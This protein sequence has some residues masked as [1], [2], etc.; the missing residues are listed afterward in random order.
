VDE[1]G[2]V[3]EIWRPSA[4]ARW[5]GWAGWSGELSGIIE[6]G[7][8]GGDEHDR[9]ATL[10]F[11][12][13]HAAA[14]L[15]QVRQ[16]WPGWAA[17]ASWRKR[18]TARARAAAGQISATAGRTRADMCIGAPRGAGRVARA[19]SPFRKVRSLP[20]LSPGAGSVS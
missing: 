20:A 15:G 3:A 1:L 10:A 7:S 14:L 19:A 12:R 18:R 17:M 16:H 8:A 5:S 6:S 13:Q 9:G 4:Q 11:E 2:N